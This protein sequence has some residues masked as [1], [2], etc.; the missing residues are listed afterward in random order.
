VGA[1]SAEISIGWDQQLF[2][3]VL[4][5]KS[6]LKIASL[7]IAS[8]WNRKRPISA[9]SKKQPALA[10]VV[11]LLSKGRDLS[12]RGYNWKQCFPVVYS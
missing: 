8:P 2:C 4:A 6:L 1:N 12:F 11:R 10:N 3:R 7:K 5:Y 9:G